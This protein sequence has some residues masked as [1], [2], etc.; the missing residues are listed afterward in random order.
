MGTN[1]SFVNS[2]RFKYPFPTKTPLIYNSPTTPI[3][4]SLWFLSSIKSWVLSTGLPIGM[5][6]GILFGSQS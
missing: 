3:G 5:L 2:S 6:L 1:F 4:K